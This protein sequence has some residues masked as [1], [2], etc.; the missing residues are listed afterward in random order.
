M[1]SKVNI[2]MKK[3]NGRKWSTELWNRLAS[4][5]CRTK[6][7]A[8]RSFIAPTNSM[9]DRLSLHSKFAT[10]I[11]RTATGTLSCLIL[12]LFKKWFAAAKF[13]GPN[14]PRAMNGKNSIQRPF[15]FECSPRNVCCVLEP[16]SCK[17]INT[18]FPP[19]K[20]QSGLICCCSAYFLL[21]IP[22][23]FTAC[24]YQTVKP[25]RP[26]PIH[27]T[28]HSNYRV[29]S[30]SSLSSVFEFPAEFLFFRRIRK[31][32]PSITH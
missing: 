8:I 27:L 26:W 4:P 17:M 11:H 9:E 23:N 28:F 30:P 15:N 2:D 18:C 22:R 20:E 6:P 5:H 3:G 10:P 19:M 16:T 7:G 29:P 32:C 21:G 1:M 24:L 12:G 13:L 25:A 31:K 14:C